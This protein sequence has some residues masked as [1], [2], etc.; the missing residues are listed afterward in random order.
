MVNLIR[1]L[2][3]AVREGLY[4]DIALAIPAVLK[5]GR[6]LDIGAGKGRL[7]IRIAQENPNLDVYG[8]DISSKSIE[9]AEI[10][11]RQA[12]F[13]GKRPRFSVGD[14][15]S[16]A[17][18]DGYFDLVVSTYSLHHWPDGVT[19]LNEVYRVLKPGG[20]AWIYDHWAD[21]TP[22]AV[23]GIRRRYGNLNYIF[24]R[25]HMHFIRHGI[26]SKQ[27]SDILN[28]PALLF[29]GGTAKENGLALLLRLKKGS[30]NRR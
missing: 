25:L 2:Y 3:S 18:E 20:E 4:Q 6:V 7:P 10:S 15:S 26:T 1:G 24:A 22:K 9:E 12:R 5:E 13:P 16:L 14:V 11:S 27:A 19:G 8:V 29:K 23:S 30:L 17:F 21:P 28:D